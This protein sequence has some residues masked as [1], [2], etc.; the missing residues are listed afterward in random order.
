MVATN[1]GEIELTRIACGPFNGLA[2]LIVQAT[3]SPG[4]IRVEAYTAGVSR[5]K[6]A[7]HP[8]DHRHPKGHLASGR[9]KPAA[10]APAVNASMPS[11]SAR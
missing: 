11:I 3:K 7:Q 2:Q 6:A 4:I 8:T 1:P 5:S 9:L 10:H